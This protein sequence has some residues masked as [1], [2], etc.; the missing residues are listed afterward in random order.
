MPSSTPSKRRNGTRRWR[1][2]FQGGD[3]G[4]RTGVGEPDQTYYERHVCG[5]ERNYSGYCNPEIDKLVNE[6][7]AEADPEKRKQLVWNIERLLAE[8]AARPV[9]FYPR[10]ATCEQP[11]GRGLT[12]MNNSIYNGWRM[13]DVWLDK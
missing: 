13:E 8:A 7:S 1:T 6:Q 3:A 9:I 12:I 5:A 11:W 10:G 2:D 4:D